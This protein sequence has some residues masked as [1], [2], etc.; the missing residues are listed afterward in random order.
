[1]IR[2]N[3][4]IK[5][6]S[7]KGLVDDAI[8]L[9]NGYDIQYKGNIVS[10]RLNDK[11]GALIYNQKK[12][13]IMEV[14]SGRLDEVLH[15]Y[16]AQSLF[17]MQTKEGLKGNKY[18]NLF[19]VPT[20]VIG[21][22]VIL[23]DPEGR[24]FTVKGSS[25]KAVLSYYEDARMVN[26]D[27]AMI[28]LDGFSAYSIHD[29]ENI[30]SCVE[31][32]VELTLLK[33]SAN[34]DDYAVAPR[35]EFINDVGTTVVGVFCCSSADKVNQINFEEDE[36]KIFAFNSAAKR[37]ISSSTV[38]TKNPYAVKGKQIFNSVSG[39]KAVV[40]YCDSKYPDG[41]CVS[42][43]EQMLA[44]ETPAILSSAKM[45]DSVEYKT[46][47]GKYLKNATSVQF[48]LDTNKSIL[49][50]VCDEGKSVAKFR[51][52]PDLT[53]IR[54]SLKK[55]GYMLTELENG[56]DFYIEDPAIACIVSNCTEFVPVSEDAVNPVNKA[57]KI[58]GSECKKTLAEYGINDQKGV[59][60][61]I[62]QII[63]N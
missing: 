55:E 24:K 18:D 34:I 11:G 62:T 52:V 39:R 40:N 54:N 2:T 26:A 14:Q 12:N 33:S 4:F 1:M 30:K 20:K 50:S 27:D 51:M 53:G 44:Y 56:L 13:T 22:S 5:T 21:N 37:N 32:E 60:S 10:V 23:E 25:P 29:R 49:S 45:N 28:L 16:I 48:R 7:D 19:F 43:M 42:A 15:R 6:L 31:N 9:E 63:V 41:L 61:S 59:F 8:T 57:G 58:I 47:Y 36:K 35:S 46:L 17:G 3:N 38:R